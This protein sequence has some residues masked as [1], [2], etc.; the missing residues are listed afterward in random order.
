VTVALWLAVT[1]A[2]L[3]TLALIPGAVRSPA[4]AA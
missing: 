3:A 4:D 2:T 1:L